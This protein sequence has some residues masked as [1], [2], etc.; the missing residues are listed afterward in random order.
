MEERKARENRRQGTTEAGCFLVSLPSPSRFSTPSRARPHPHDPQHLAQHRNNEPGRDDVM[1]LLL[2]FILYSTRAW[3][4]LASTWYLPGCCST[5]GAGV[6]P[7]LAEELRVA[8]SR[9]IGP[10]STTTAA[11]T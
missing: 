10:F 8:R 9:D 2:N 3:L 1:T 6:G 4:L 11:E 7:M 5:R